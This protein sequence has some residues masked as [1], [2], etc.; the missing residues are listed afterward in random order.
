MELGKE[1]VKKGGRFMEAS[2]DG[3]RL[4]LEKRIFSQIRKVVVSPKSGLKREQREGKGRVDTA[5]VRAVKGALVSVNIQL[6]RGWG[7]R[8]PH[9]GDDRAKKG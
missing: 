2:R 3:M 6:V 1:K 4:L 5:Q 9:A 8:Y 7:C